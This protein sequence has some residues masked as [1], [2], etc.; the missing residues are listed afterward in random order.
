MEWPNQYQR[1][2]V[3]VSLALGD[4]GFQVET[5]LDPTGDILLEEITDFINQFGNKEE[6]RL[7]FYFAGH[8]YTKE[9]RVVSLNNR[10]RRI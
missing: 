10:R 5:R 3:A 7:L 6:N 1:K 8:G 9:S 2:I 4:Q